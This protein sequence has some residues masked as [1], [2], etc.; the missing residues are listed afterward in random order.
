MK[1]LIRFTFMAAAM[2]LG[3]FFWFVNSLP[4]ANSAVVLPGKTEATGIVVLTGGGGTRIEAGVGLLA[5]GQARRMLI[6]GVN[7]VTRKED[8]AAKLPE[9]A[10]LF[11]CCIDLGLEALTTRGNALE[12]ED[13]SRENGLSSLIVVTSDY[14]MPR[15]LAELRKTR[16][17][18][19]L[20]PY[21]VASN[22][23]PGANWWRDEAKLR[24]L[25]KEYTK[26]LAAKVK[27]ALGIETA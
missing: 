10:A 21:P 19:T 26:F 18:V 16:P 14:H 11:D 2:W 20:L 27:H 3:G 22:G 1:L 9:Q 17:G 5:T 7:P 24:L 25:A 15:A 13:W 6:S 23:T 4:D 8:L 12:A